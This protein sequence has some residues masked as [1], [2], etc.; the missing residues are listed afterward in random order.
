MIRI[1]IR[2]SQFIMQADWPGYVT[3][4]SFGATV[5]AQKNVMDDRG[6]CNTIT[7]T[8]SIYSLYVPNF[9]FHYHTSNSSKSFWA[10]ISK[11]LCFSFPSPLRST[12]AWVTF[13]ILFEIICAIMDSSIVVKLRLEQLMPAQKPILTVIG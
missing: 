5:W 11:I 2:Y 4:S 6:K 10:I 12:I 3:S 1:G 13:S 7:N 9:F 8:E